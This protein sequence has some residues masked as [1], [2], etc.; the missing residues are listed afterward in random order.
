MLNFLEQD[1]NWGH[2][3]F[4]ASDAP[5]P[6]RLLFIRSRSNR[7]PP[8]SARHKRWGEKKILVTWKMIT[9][10]RPGGP[11]QDSS[12]AAR[13]SSAGDQK[14][15]TRTVADSSDT[16]PRQTAYSIISCDI[17]PARP[18]TAPAQ[19]QPPSVRRTTDCESKASLRADHDRIAA[20]LDG[21]CSGLALR[22]GGT[23]SLGAS[24]ASLSMIGDGRRCRGP[25]G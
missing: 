23:V 12:A 18:V 15:I 10:S 7:P 16:G 21:L 5:N 24:R 14:T 19:Q 4:R 22:L 8:N 1:Q 6:K 20:L 17:S 9:N 11:G 2:K 25:A 3:L 13:R